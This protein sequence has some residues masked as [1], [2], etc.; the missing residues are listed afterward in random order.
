MLRTALA[1]ALLALALGA[2]PTTAAAAKFTLSS[3]AVR[4][5]AT[6]PKKYVST[7]S[8]GENVALPLVW[9][10]AP[11]GTRSFAITMFDPMPGAGLGFVHWVLYGIP[12]DRTALREGEAN[13]PSLFVAGKNSFGQTGWFGPEPP[14]ADSAHPY[15]IILAATDLAPNALPPGMT[16]DQLIA[17]L[18]GHVLRAATFVARYPKN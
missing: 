17:A 10:N 12:A 13:N 3:P 1:S 9:R 15:I 4:Y 14:P 11:E 7:R 8:G 16:R 5:G 18:Q 6:F 2:A